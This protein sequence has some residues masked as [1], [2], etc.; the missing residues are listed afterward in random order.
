[1]IAKALGVHSDHFRRAVA[2][3]YYRDPLKE[4]DILDVAAIARMAY[5]MV[6]NLGHRVG[7]LDSGRRGEWLTIK[8]VQN[9]LGISR[10]TIHRHLKRRIFQKRK[11]RGRTFVHFSEVSIYLTA[12]GRLRPQKNK[13]FVQRA[14]KNPRNARLNSSKNGADTRCGSD[15]TQPEVNP[16]PP[17]SIDGPEAPVAA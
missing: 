2:Q 6:L 12:L 4:L 7:Q 17:G 11:I 14:S 8:D 5:D 15:G 1:M 9:L 13:V 16:E 10:A 3:S